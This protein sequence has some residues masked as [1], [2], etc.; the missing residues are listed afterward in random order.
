MAQGSTELRS[1]KSIPSR[2]F[3]RYKQRENM[4]MTLAAFHLTLY[5]LL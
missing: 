3:K 2:L 4:G 1:G 5:S